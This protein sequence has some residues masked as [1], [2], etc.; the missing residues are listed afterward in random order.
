M[1]KKQLSFGRPHYLFVGMGL[2]MGLGPGVSKP[3]ELGPSS[4]HTP[5]ATFLYFKPGY[6]FFLKRH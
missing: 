1:F 5:G 6:F 3:L 4:F 2:G